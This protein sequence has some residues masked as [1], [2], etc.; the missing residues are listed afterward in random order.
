MISPQFIIIDF[1]NQ[2]KNESI[3]NSDFRAEHPNRP[4]SFISSATLL[5]MWNTFS[6]WRLGLSTLRIWIR[7]SIQRMGR[8]P[9]Y[10]PWL[11]L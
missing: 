2:Y 1:P 8:G 3:N 10:Q 7:R 4:I 11:T 6:I 5:P 9:A